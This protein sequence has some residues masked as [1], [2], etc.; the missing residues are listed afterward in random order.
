MLIQLQF[1]LVI[2][3]IS[4]EITT[5][6]KKRQVNIFKGKDFPKSCAKYLCIFWAEPHLTL[7]D[8]PLCWWG[9]P[10]LYL[11]PSLSEQSI[12]PL[13]TLYTFLSIWKVA[14]VSS[15][16]LANV[17]GHRNLHLYLIGA[18]VGYPCWCENLTVGRHSF[19]LV[20]SW[21]VFGWLLRRCRLEA[22]RWTGRPWK[23]GPEGWTGAC[24]GL[25]LPPFQGPPTPPCL[26][27]LNLC[28]IMVVVGLFIKILMEAD[29]GWL[30]SS[31]HPFPRVI[32]AFLFT[33]TWNHP[34]PSGSFLIDTFEK[35]SIL[36]W[37]LYR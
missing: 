13:D 18:G 6:L 34:E 9:L 35:I 30:V 11:V 23:V 37:Y 2:F 22:A 3:R 7:W 8:S 5:K 4:P 10:L 24:Q 31:Y 32:P 29:Q 20:F 33:I 12:N 1:N 16:T 14:H 15:W 25:L 26:S 17:N 19:W 28:T 27:H 36:I 21:L